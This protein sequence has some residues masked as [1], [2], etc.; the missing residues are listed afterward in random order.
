MPAGRIPF[1]KL[2][3]WVLTGF[4]NSPKKINRMTGN[5]DKLKEQRNEIILDQLST[6]GNASGGKEESETS[7]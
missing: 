2:F 7:F 6:A 5:F 4:S 1:H 3:L